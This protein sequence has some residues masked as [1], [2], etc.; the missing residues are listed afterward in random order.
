MAHGFVHASGLSSASTAGISP[1]IL[2]HT[3]SHSGESRY[4]NM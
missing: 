3:C 1:A 2:P 4:M